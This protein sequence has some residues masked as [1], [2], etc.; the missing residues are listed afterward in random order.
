MTKILIGADPELFAKVD[1]KLVSAYG[2]LAGTK[3]APQKV[4]KGAVQIDGMALEFNIDPAA[5]EQEFITNIDTVMRIMREM[6]GCEYAIQPV[7]DFGEDYMRQ[8]PKEALELG[9]DP[10]FNAW[11]CKVNDRPN[12]DRPFRT[13]A[14]HI[15]IGFCNDGEPDNTAYL[16]F[17][18]KLVQQMDFFLGLPSLVL[19]THKD[20]ARR[21][22]LYGKA[23]AF[24][25]KKYGFEYRTLSNF[26]L[27]TD[28]LKSWA[29]KNAIMAYEAF[30]SGLVLAEKYGDIQKII[31]TT[32]IKSAEKIIKAEGLL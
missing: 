16:A 23:G 21:R 20:S 8:Q 17:V 18:A 26:W 24:R 11:T 14:G 4:E 15:H 19:D 31:N 12:G 27:A 5:S 1:G 6:A 7:A 10:D 30:E 32:D 29:Y 13:A 25:P 2:M 9:C 28:A 22:E 3:H